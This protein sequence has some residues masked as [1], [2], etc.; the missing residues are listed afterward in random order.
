[1]YVSRQCRLKKQK[2]LLLFGLLCCWVPPSHYVLWTFGVWSRIG[3]TVLCFKKSFSAFL[4]KTDT[5]AYFTKKINF[6]I[7]ILEGNINWSIWKIFPHKTANF[8]T[9]WVSAKY[10]FCRKWINFNGF[11]WKIY[12]WKR[13]LVEFSLFFFF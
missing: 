9:M 11:G 6:Y 7:S 3:M 5:L 4:G 8:Y 12:L 2:D 10:D 13:Y 1:M